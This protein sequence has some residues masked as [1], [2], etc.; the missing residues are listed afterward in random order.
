MMFGDVPSVYFDDPNGETLSH[1]DRLSDRNM[2][3]FTNPDEAL[4]AKFQG[5]YDKVLQEMQS[6]EPG[7]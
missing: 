7:R 2:Y 3:V 1:W 4:T 6:A 5:L